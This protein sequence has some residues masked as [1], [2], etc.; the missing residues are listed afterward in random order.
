MESRTA[1]YYTLANIAVAEET[2]PFPITASPDSAF[3][4]PRFPGSVPESAV[5]TFSTGYAW[6]A[7]S[8]VPYPSPVTTI[9]TEDSHAES[10]RL[11]RVEGM[12]FFNRWVS[13]DFFSQWL[14]SSQGST[15]MGQRS[16]S[17]S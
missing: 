12:H 2:Y 1:K 15:P 3:P 9:G 16:N 14:E 11:G 7:D 6:T 4:F 13:H 17:A 10:P 5:P 8:S